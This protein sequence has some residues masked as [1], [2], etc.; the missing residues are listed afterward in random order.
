VIKC[1]KC[2]TCFQNIT[3]LVSHLSNPKSKCKVN[4]KQ[5]YDTFIKKE[6]EGVCQFCGNETL[7]YGLSK[8]YPNNV[9]K[10]CRNNRKESKELRK[11]N[12][13]NKKENKRI[14]SGYYNYSEECKICKEKE[15]VYKCKTKENLSKHIIAKHKEIKLQD[16]YDKYIKVNQEEGKCKIS[17][18]KTSFNGLSNGYLIY[19]NKGTNSKDI[20]IQKKKEET[21]LK[22]YGVSNL[23]FVNQ[24]ERIESFKKTFEERRKLRKVR[25]DLLTLLRKLSIDKIDKLQ[26]QICGKKYNNFHSITL[27]IFKIHKISIQIYYDKYFKKEIEGICP[28]SKLKTNFDCLE[29][30]YFKYHKLFIT[31]TKEIKDGSKKQQQYYIQS[32]IKSFQQIFDVEFI[33]LDSINLIGDLT[34]IKC[35][36]CNNIYE[37][38]FTNLISGFG[39]CQKCYPKNTH[40]S[41]CEISLLENL[42][43]ITVNE[44]ILNNYVGLI[45]NPKTNRPLELDIYFPSKKIAVEF[46]GLYWHSE[47][48]LNEDAPTY[49]VIK[50]NQC[51]KEGIQLFQIFEDEWYYKKRYNN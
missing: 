30:G 31:Y 50:W 33:N 38:R 22:N 2:K 28:L 35:L 43:L 46:N 27:H 24:K 21:L 8:G 40:K 36:K 39:K 41:T 17:G 16:Y 19:K 15:V 13:K 29:R 32:K 26:C 6:R 14:Q 49:H 5:Y 12:Y 9:C 25:Y 20:K 37:N 10:H 4:I 44:T 7:F 18:E 1:L 42:K 51:K 47:L 34:K 11:T 45:K 3:Q 23:S 48:I